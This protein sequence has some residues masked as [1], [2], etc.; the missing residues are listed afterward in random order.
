MRWS[1]PD[2]LGHVNHTRA[3]S[4]IEDARLAMAGGSG[5]ALILA[6]LEAD[7]LRQPT[8]ASASALAS[9]AG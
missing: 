3:L 7:Y 9:P 4:L 6:R 2:S 5:G 1:D 8:T